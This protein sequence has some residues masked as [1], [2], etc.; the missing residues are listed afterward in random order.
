MFGQTTQWSKDLSIALASSLPNGGGRCLRHSLGHM[1]LD[2]MSNGM[3]PPTLRRLIKICGT[4]LREVHVIGCL[5][6]LPKAPWAGL[7][8]WNRP[9]TREGLLPP[10][11][12]P[13]RAIS[14][15]NTL[16]HPRSMLNGY[17]RFVD[18]STLGAWWKQIMSHQVSLLRFGVQFCGHVDFHLLLRCGGPNHL[19]SLLL[20]HKTALS[21]L[22][23]HW[24]L[25]PCLSQ[26]WWQHGILKPNWRNNQGNMQDFVGSRTPTLVSR[27]S[28][29][30]RH[31]GL[32]FC[33]NLSGPKWL[34]SIAMT[35][36][37]FLIM[38]VSLSQSLRFV[39]KA[40]PFLSFTMI[41]I[42]FGFKVLKV[43]RLVTWFLKSD[44]L[45]HSKICQM[46]SCKCGR[47]DGCATLMSQK[48]GG[49]SS[50]S[51]PRPISLRGNF[52]GVALTQLLCSKAFKPKNP[53]PH[54]DLMVWLGKIWSVCPRQCIRPFVTFFKLRKY[55]VHGHNNWWM[56]RLL[57]WPRF[58][59]QLGLL[60]FALSQ[61]LVF[62]TGV[63]L[64]GMLKLHCNTLLPNS[65]TPSMGAD[66]VTMLLRSGPNF[67]GPLRFRLLTRLLL[68]D[69]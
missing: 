63:G 23:V 24:L 51:L 46:S 64:H 13:E 40:R 43:S 39:G 55:Q 33:C 65:L 67:C 20:P 66:Q 3:H 61:F 28:S 1:T 60:I 25:M 36:V 34:M 15:T 27:T 22:R 4:T 35:V 56:E 44:A 14:S 19:S 7:N 53:A 52:S 48:A 6:R 41:L 69:W 18:F 11:R 12:L 21:F 29:L 47:S 10:S 59:N 49:R 37:L 62:C 8:T 58:P 2:S 54:A 5:F 9:H 45:E 31:Q 16:A 38:R 32:T 50:S 26:S 30:Q 42:A 57:A 68:V 17:A